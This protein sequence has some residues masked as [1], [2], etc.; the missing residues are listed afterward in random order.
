MTNLANGVPG[1]LDSQRW[2]KKDKYRQAWIKAYQD[3]MN[4]GIVGATNDT[5]IWQLQ[6]KGDPI[7]LDNMS[8]VDR[9]MYQ[10]AAYYIQ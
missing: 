4:R 9:E 8:N 2:A 6:H 7:T 1:Y 5:G 3:I 10:D